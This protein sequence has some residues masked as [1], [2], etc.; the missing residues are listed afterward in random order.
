VPQVERVTADDCLR[1]A[2]AHLD[3]SK[4][5]TLVV[6]DVDAVGA[7]LVGLNLGEPVVLSPGTF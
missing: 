3:P 5:T 6:G 1:V 2:K 7:D 4:L